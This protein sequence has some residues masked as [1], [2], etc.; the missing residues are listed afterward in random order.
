MNEPIF[1]LNLILICLEDFTV[2]GTGITF[3][4]Y[5]NH[6]YRIN[7][8]L[9]KWYEENGHSWRIK[10][11]TDDQFKHQGW[12][13]EKELLEKFANLKQQ[14]KEKI[15]KINEKNVRKLD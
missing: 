3:S 12:F 7:K 1:K 5:K 6:T 9:S 4:Y 11:I 8:Y 14:R 2:P 15:L 13:T 10:N